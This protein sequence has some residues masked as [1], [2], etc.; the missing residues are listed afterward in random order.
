MV[1]LA[2]MF[3]ATALALPILVGRKRRDAAVPEEPAILPWLEEDAFED[4]F[5]KQFTTDHEREL[6]E[7]DIETS[8]CRQL[9]DSDH[10]KHLIVCPGRTSRTLN[11]IVLDDTPH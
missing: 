3:P 1:A 6:S 4:G 7:K 8:S 2:A 10:N 11:M 9:I 5:V